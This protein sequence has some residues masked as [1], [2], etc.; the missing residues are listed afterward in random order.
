MS[1]WRGYGSS[2]SRYCIKFHTASI[3]RANPDVSDA[4]AVVYDPTQQRQLLEQMLGVHFKTL[5]A[6]DT[7]DVDGLVYSATAS[8]FLCAFPL[9]VRFKNS[10]F[11]EEREWRFVFV[12]DGD[13]PS[14]LGFFPS[15]GIMKPFRPLLRGGADER[16][17]IAEVVAG[18]SRS[19]THAVRSARLLLD[20]FGYVDVPVRASAIPLVL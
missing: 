6:V 20:H 11:V 10:A 2:D 18:A 17:P 12:D 7:S 9:L 3:R 8:I 15:A 13:D 5:I 4:M 16:L 19:D 1:Q 14:S